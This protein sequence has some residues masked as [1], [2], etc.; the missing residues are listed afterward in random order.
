M[1]EKQTSSSTRNSPTAA[2]I[3][4]TDEDVDATEITEEG[5]PGKYS[6]TDGINK[7]QIIEKNWGTVAL[8]QTKCNYKED[9]KVE[10]EVDIK[11]DLKGDAIICMANQTKECTNDKDKD[12][13]EKVTDETTV[14]K[15]KDAEMKTQGDCEE[16][17]GK[18]SDENAMKT[19]SEDNGTCEEEKS[20]DLKN[21]GSGKFAQNC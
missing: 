2:V 3:V 7:T 14:G 8:Q 1:S 16:M 18:E 17:T 13:G 5:I 10:M 9:T 4:S 11:I 12:S 19:I 15:S 20:D 21:D 6:H